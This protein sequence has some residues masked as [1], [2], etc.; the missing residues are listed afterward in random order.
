MAYRDGKS[1]LNSRTDWRMREYVSVLGIKGQRGFRQGRFSG[2]RTVLNA[3]ASSLYS[4]QGLRLEGREALCGTPPCP[5]I[6]CLSKSPP[7]APQ[8]HS[9][10]SLS[11]P[12]EP[13]V[14]SRE[15]TRRPWG[16]RGLPFL[17][18]SSAPWLLN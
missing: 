8:G 5:V 1:M 18:P 11:L 12:A 4:E 14:V 15:R 7:K 10:P 17:E 16:N 6:A 2:W 13:G 9:W 3:A